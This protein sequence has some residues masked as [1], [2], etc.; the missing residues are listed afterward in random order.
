VTILKKIGI[1]VVCAATLFAAVFWCFTLYARWRTPGKLL[2]CA[3][4]KNRFARGY[5]LSKAPPVPGPVYEDEYYKF[6]VLKGSMFAKTPLGYGIWLPGIGDMYIKEFSSWA[7]YLKYN[8]R[9]IERN[10]EDYA[11]YA[12][13]L[14]KYP[15]ITPKPYTGTLGFDVLV[16]EVY[17]EIVPE[18]QR[19]ITL[20]SGERGLDFI[21]VNSPAYCR[22]ALLQR[23]SGHIV[24]IS[25]MFSNDPRREGI[26]SVEFDLLLS[27]LVLKKDLPD[28]SV[29]NTDYFSFVDTYLYPVSLEGEVKSIWRYLPE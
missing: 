9:L 15:Q 19:A 1:G 3:V 26:M 10:R 2:F 16:P 20:Q 21:G 23:K 22:Y 28:N 24:E 12:A 6:R 25:L 27:S 29:N 8:A 13:Y 14:R 11:K 18:W 17:G 5:V 7:K 4:D